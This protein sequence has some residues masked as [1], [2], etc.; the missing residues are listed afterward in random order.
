MDGISIIQEDKRS[1][2]TYSIALHELALTG[3]R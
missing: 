3:M 1:V 2:F